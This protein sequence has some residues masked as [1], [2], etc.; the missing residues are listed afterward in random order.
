MIFNYLLCF[1]A[2]G[3]IN[4][5]G[6][7]SEQIAEK[8]FPASVMLVLFDE[9]GQ[10]VKSGSGFFVSPNVVATNYHVVENTS[11]GVVKFLGRSSVSKIENV[12][13][14]NPTFDIALLQID[15]TSPVKLDLGDSKNLKIGQSVYVVG[16]PQ[17]LEGTFSNGL[18]S[19]IRKFGEDYLVQMTAPIS[20]GSSGGPVL[21]N[22]GK[23]IGVSVGMVQGGQ[24]LNF[25]IPSEYVVSLLK[26]V[27]DKKFSRSY[28]SSRTKDFFSP[29]LS[30]SSELIQENHNKEKKYVSTIHKLEF[31][32]H[33]R[34]STNKKGKENTTDN[35][36]IMSR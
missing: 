2:L 23:V 19:S 30:L 5:L 9:T 22:S 32:D 29:T 28:T 3:G 25:A 31:L 36:F 8:A 18:V 12:V 13:A 26:L 6:L 4:L 35:I 17:G 15:K 14:V 16:N 34:G 27:E 11:G 7:T 10:A 1:T 33:S 20:S 21:D 24:N